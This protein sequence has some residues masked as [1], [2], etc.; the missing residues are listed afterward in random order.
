LAMRTMLIT[1]SATFLCG[2]A[3][4]QQANVNLD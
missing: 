4:A 2:S 3:L 1:L